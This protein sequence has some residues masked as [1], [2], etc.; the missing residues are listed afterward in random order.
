MIDAGDAA[1]PLSYSLPDTDRLNTRLYR[2]ALICWLAPLVVGVGTL[3]AYAWTFWEW[4]PI[5]GLI[6]LGVGTILFVV[7]IG[8]II[9]FCD[10]IRR[11]EPA[12]H[13]AWFPRAARAAI[14]LVS[15]V[16]VA[17]TCA[18]VGL[19]LTNYFPVT[20]VNQTSAPIMD[21][22][23][24]AT[25]GIAELKRL[26]PGEKRRLLVLPKGEGEV[27]FTAMQN[28]GPVTGLA[29]GYVSSGMGGRSQVT[30][31]NS[32]PVITTNR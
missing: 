29:A 31:T 19:S 28:G 7:G 16:F 10:N 8:C 4:L 2:A 22:T 25:G 32:G 18:I 11:C 27:T 30:F 12:I 24:D 14:L 23:I 9:A 5:L 15:S 6:T 26:E 3:A 13:K 21:I 20:L 1:L 17:P